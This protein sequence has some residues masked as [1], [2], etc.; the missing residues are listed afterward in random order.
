MA[1]IVDALYKSNEN[2]VTAQ[3]KGNFSL[4]SVKD[5]NDYLITIRHGIVLVSE[6]AI[7]TRHELS[8]MFF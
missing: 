4:C 3:T 7:Q 2:S 6:D 8:V 1:D 5:L